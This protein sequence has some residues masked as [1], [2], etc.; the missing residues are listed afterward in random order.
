VFLTKDQ[1][2]NGDAIAILVFKG[3]TALR[4]C[5]KADIAAK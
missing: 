2:Q 4:P 1:R 5:R 3:G